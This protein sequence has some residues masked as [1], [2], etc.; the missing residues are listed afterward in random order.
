M[1][2]LGVAL[3]WSMEKLPDISGVTPG[4]ALSVL[5]ILQEAVTNA[6]KHGTTKTIRIQG[7]PD[8]NGAAI[9]IGNDAAENDDIGSGHGLNNMRRRAEALGG[10]VQFERDA[11]QATLTLSLPLRLADR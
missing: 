10:Q 1:R 4:N 6:I 8:I 2:R 7:R 5:R 11:N 9:T 3:D